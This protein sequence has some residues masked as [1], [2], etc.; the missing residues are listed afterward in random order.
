MYE[1]HRQDGI[2]HE[3]IPPFKTSVKEGRTLDG[4]YPNPERAMPP[5]DVGL[6]VPFRPGEG[7][8]HFQGYQDMLPL[9]RGQAH[10]T[11]KFECLQVSYVQCSVV[12]ANVV[13]LK[14]VHED[15]GMG[16]CCS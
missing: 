9:K 11:L 7:Q 1:G 14:E 3:Q 6:S 8:G 5:V 15:L 2:S 10:A 13:F 4:Q 12:G 16:V